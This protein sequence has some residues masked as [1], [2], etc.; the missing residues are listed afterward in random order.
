MSWVHRSLLVLGLISSL[1]GILLIVVPSLGGIVSP[2]GVGRTAPFALI[3]IIAVV[4]AARYGLSGFQQTTENGKK[5]RSDDVSL[6]T[7]ENRPPYM[8]TGTRLAQRLK[9][10]KWTDRRE[11]DP[12]NRRQLRT[13]LREMA[14]RVLSQTENWSRTEIETRLDNG[15]WS[16]NPQAAAFFADDLVPSLSFRQRLLAPLQSSEPIFARRARHVI[17]E[18][19]DRTTTIK[20]RP[21]LPE[22]TKR[23]LNEDPPVSIRQYWSSDATETTR[24]SRTSGTYVVT[25]SALA[26]GGI[27]ILTLR[28]ALFLLTL[29]G[30]T[31][32][33]YA[34]VASAP[35]GAVEVRR[36]LSDTE[37]E[38]GTEIEVTVVVRNVSGTT[39][40]DLRLI[41]GVP[42]GLTVIDGSPRF[43]TALRPGKEA[44]FSYSIEAIHGIHT[45]DSA[46][47]I[48]RDVTGSRK[49]ETLVETAATTLSCQ[50]PTHPI[51]SSLRQQTTVHAGQA[52]STVAG[53]GV[54]F[55]SVRDYQPGD[56]VSR[57]DWKRKA[58]TGEFTTIDFQET[59]LEKVL[60]LIDARTE[61]YR[62]TAGEGDKP[63]IQKGVIAGHHITSQLLTESVPVG[64]MALSPRSCWLSPSVGDAHLRQIQN[65][66]AGDPSF[67]WTIPT[68][69]FD[70]TTAL[71]ELYQRLSLDTQIIFISP[72]CDDAA[73]GVARRLDAYGYGVSVISPDPTA[74]ASSKLDCGWGYA[75][76]ERRFR[77][78]SLR[79]AKIPVI[80]WDPSKSFTE[81]MQYEV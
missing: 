22:A 8:E 46:L 38:P 72:L 37:P 75:K 14:I 65:T 47:L 19:A 43:S 25:A 1:I 41:D 59:R 30:V 56:P 40:T 7:P 61:A 58:K 81:V 62:A 23:P 50:L 31:V 26:A 49:R 15:S 64:L 29:F 67:D 48:T 10:I 77:L 76:L 2:S 11:G 18:I 6:P 74:S 44:T 20:V 9:T 21:S 17:A 3:G 70:T 34:R 71:R 55:H 57:I 27:G 42:P 24:A 35:T 80:D 54:E 53:S 69:E 4:L 32:A 36:T 60:V 12:T 13:D 79:N 28:P 78:T 66:L 16:E 33:G 51:E 5:E 63:I 39:I 73:V 45:F 68:D 52:R